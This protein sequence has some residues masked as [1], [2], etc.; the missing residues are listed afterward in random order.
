MANRNVESRIQCECGLGSNRAAN[1]LK[2]S[3]C[4]I[5]YELGIYNM[6]E[7][8]NFQKR[9]MFVVHSRQCFSHFVTGLCKNE[10]ESLQ[11]DST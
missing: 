1:D 11:M 9:L 2:K 8:A 4:K 7:I 5:R 3:I 10:E 6:I